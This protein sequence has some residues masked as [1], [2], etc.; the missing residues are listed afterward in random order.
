MADVL[1]PH[2][3]VGF[4]MYDADEHYYEPHDVFSRHIERPFRHLIRWADVNGRRELLV[5]H[6]V[7]S[8]H[9]NP[10]F[11]P[12]GRPGAMSEYYRGHNRDGRTPAELVG[13]PEPIR[14]EFRY[15]DARVAALD[16]QGVACTWMIPSLGLG[17]EELLTDNPAGLHAAFRAFN[18]WL[19]D[20]WGFDRDGRILAAPLFTLVDPIAAE[21]E[22]RWVLDRGAKLICFRPAPVVG[23]YGGRSPGDPAHDRFW[24]MAAEAGVV[25]VYHSADSGYGRFAEQWGE[26][27]S[28]KGWKDT[29]FPELLSL[30]IERPIFDTLSALIGHGVFD[31]HPNLRVATVEL[32]SGWVFDLFRRMKNAYGK[33]PHLFGR[34]PVETFQSNIWVTPF[35]E[36]DLEALIDLV[37]VDHVLFGSDWPHPEG[38]AEPAVYASDVESFAEPV[39]RSIMS[40]NFK[41]LMGLG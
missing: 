38:L 5:G 2:V 21:E 7:F 30:H 16:R 11:D 8:M 14:P 22:L 15:R 9:A 39:R 24:S 37:G 29:P 36:D 25:V 3:A 1:Q 19:D 40:D 35:Y 6:R 34:D 26:R 41:S 10:G 23:P 20:D 12:V 27:A 13:E 33:I 32:G 17:I 28:F 18:R 31:R 4:P